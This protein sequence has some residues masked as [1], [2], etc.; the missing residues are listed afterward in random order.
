MEPHLPC[1]GRLESDVRRDAC[2]LSQHLQPTVIDFSLKTNQAILHASPM[3]L[4]I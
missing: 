3:R 4:D 2:L 1:S